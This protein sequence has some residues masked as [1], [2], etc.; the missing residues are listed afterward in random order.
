MGGDPRS[1][2]GRVL[3]PALFGRAAA[4]RSAAVD[5]LEARLMVSARK[6]AELKTA[7]VGVEIAVLEPMDNSVR[8]VQ[9]E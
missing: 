2:G 1:A 6:F 9:W 7:P 5:S 4:C 3:P 8:A